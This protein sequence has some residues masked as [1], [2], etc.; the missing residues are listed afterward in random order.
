MRRSVKKATKTAIIQFEESLAN[1]K[2]NPKR[3][4]SYINSKQKIKTK[5]NTMRTNSG[6]VTSDKVEIAN[7]LNQ[8]F[9][10]VFVYE[11]FNDI[12]PDFPKRTD[13]EISDLKIEL[14]IIK[15]KL[16]KLDVSKSQ[17]NDEV[18]PMSFK[19]APLIGQFHFKLFFN[20]H[21]I[22][23]YYQTSGLKPM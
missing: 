19:N 10:S 20:H 1:D 2:K 16:E 4:F 23:A 9:N 7:L 3:L 13:H 5:L 8:H 12:M 22:K 18:H 11:P 21:L 6:D 17:G 14:L 15:L